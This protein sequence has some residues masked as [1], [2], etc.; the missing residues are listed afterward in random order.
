MKKIIFICHGNI[1]RSTMAE[2]IAKQ[3]IEANNLKDMFKIES[4]AT[5]YEEIGNAPDRR[6]MK[7]LQE[8]EIP[9]KHLDGKKA[10]RLEAREYDYWDYFICM[11]SNN[12]RNIGY[13]FKEDCDNKI[14][15]VS[16]VSQYQVGDVADP[17]YTGDFKIT[18]DQLSKAV[19]DIIEKIKNK[20]I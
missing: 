16:D 7:M 15:K 20:I 17:W 1:C 11:D 14:F 12:I 10:R 18:Y 13:I 8:K 2:A 9:L 4:A 6:T 5:S 3:Y 19:P